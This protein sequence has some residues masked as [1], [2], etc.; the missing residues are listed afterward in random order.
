MPIVHTAI[1]SVEQNILSVLETLSPENK[2]TTGGF[3]MPKQSTQPTRF[4]QKLV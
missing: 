1:N 2:K 4:F 3:P